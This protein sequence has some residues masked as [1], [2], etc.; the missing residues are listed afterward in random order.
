MTDRHQSVS[1]V[2]CVG[3]VSRQIQKHYWGDLF[4]AV[5]TVRS[6]MELAQ[7]VHPHHSKHKTGDYWCLML[8]VVITHKH[9]LSFP[10]EH[11]D[12]NAI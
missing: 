3:A 2:I 6:H 7:P 1:A 10:A 5:F 4:G 12:M 11:L 8:S 9:V